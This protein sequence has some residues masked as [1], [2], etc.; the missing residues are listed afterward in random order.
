[1]ES[2]NT[3]NKNN[4]QT[5]AQGAAVNMLGEVLSAV[6]EPLL[7]VFIS[8]MLG[9]QTLGTY[10]LVTYYIAI[11]FRLALLGFDRG[12]LRHIPIS[13]NASDPIKAEASVLGTS[14]RWVAVLSLAITAVV[15]LFPDPFLRMGNE[16]HNT[17]TTWWLAVLILALP[18]KTLVRIPLFATRGLSIM[19]IFVT[20]QNVIAPLTL[21]ILSVLP[22]FFGFGERSL[23]FGFIASAYATLVAG[24]IFYKPLFHRQTLL[25]VLRAP[26]DLELIRFSWPIGLTEILTFLIARLDIIMIAA[27]FPDKPELV[28]FYG[29]AALIAGVSKKVRLSFDTSF[30]PVIAQL[31]DQGDT[32]A[33]KDLYNRVGRWIFSLFIL[34]GGAIALLSIFILSI[35][36]PGFTDY[37]LVVPILIAGRLCNG[38]GGSAQ[39]ALLMAGR[40]KLELF[41]TVLANLI[42]LGLNLYMIP[43]YG[44]FGAAIAT[45]IALN[46][47][48]GLRIAQVAA[49]LNV[50]VNPWSVVKILMAGILALIPSGLMIWASPT[51]LTSLACGLVFLLLYPCSL[52]LVGE[53]SD[54]KAAWR[55]V[56][57]RLRRY[58]SSR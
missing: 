31:H 9:A 10:V 48:T 34:V 58:R 19:W 41:D 27:F 26:R 11:F 40:S 38:A 15:A 16:M 50:W 47:S 39:A 1:M 6:G 7:F 43:R 28:A 14:Y 35:Y 49:L 45:S 54:V 32:D 44:V 42:N 12:V 23:A 4:S 36:G 37:W 52:M 25:A 29:I 57:D 53:R 22:L 55:I 18:A 3:P 8:H 56:S 5:I 30:S 20:V 24:Y 13:Q 17:D 2:T 33:M 21:L 46:L 51:P